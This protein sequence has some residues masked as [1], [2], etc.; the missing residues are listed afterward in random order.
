MR[1]YRES[2]EEYEFNREAFRQYVDPLL[3]RTKD[4]KKTRN[5]LFEEW[6]SVL[7]VSPDSLKHWYTDSQNKR[8]DPMTLQNIIDLGNVLNIDYHLLLKLKKVGEKTD[9]SMS[10]ILEQNE[11]IESKIDSII[12]LLKHVQSDSTPEDSLQECTDSQK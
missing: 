8:S 9:M 2:N 12:E 7:G 6:A 4:G 1:T 3:G 11:R 5:A 10:K